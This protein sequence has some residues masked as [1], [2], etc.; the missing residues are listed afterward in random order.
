M[1][2]EDYVEKTFPI[3]CKGRNSAGNE[4]LSEPVAVDVKIYK[5]PGCNTISSEVICLYKT[6]AHGQ[7]CRASHPEGVDKVGEGVNGP[8][9]FSIP[10]SLEIGRSLEIGG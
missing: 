8:Y 2:V 5:S 3:K 10:Y 4:T 9:S 6:G 7:R 1:A